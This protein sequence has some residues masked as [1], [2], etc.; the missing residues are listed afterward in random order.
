MLTVMIVLSYIK[1]NGGHDAAAKVVI[2]SEQAG[3]R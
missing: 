3:L 1:V 2:S